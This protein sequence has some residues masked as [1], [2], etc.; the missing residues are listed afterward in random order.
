ME[1]K[2]TMHKKDWTKREC[3]GCK[4][5]NA[6]C[7]SGICFWQQSTRKITIVKKDTG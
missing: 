7:R 4:Q 6:E 1:E 5:Y 2:S 3:N